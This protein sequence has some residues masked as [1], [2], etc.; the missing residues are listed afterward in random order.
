[1]I[2]RGR[3]VARGSLDEVTGHASAPVRVRCSDPER[4]LAA[5]RRD[6]VVAQLY[7][8]EWLA[9]RGA[10]LESVGTTALRNE[11]AVYELFREPQTLE[12]VFLELTGETDA[13][14]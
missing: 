2:S 3:L 7:G 8:R 13:G 5:L 6:G 12:D 14:R 1:V 9:V 4:L 11:I 10:P